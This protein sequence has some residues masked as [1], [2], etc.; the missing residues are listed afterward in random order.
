MMAGERGREEEVF[1]YTAVLFPIFSDSAP[2]SY[3]SESQ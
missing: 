2:I 1:I 3:S